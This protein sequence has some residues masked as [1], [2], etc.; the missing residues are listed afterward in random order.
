MTERIAVNPQVHFGK[1]CVAGTRIPV[2]QVLEL[3]PSEAGNHRVRV[4][5]A[6]GVPQ[7]RSGL[8]S[9]DRTGEGAAVVVAGAPGPY[10]AAP[11]QGANTEATSA[12]M[13]IRSPLTPLGYVE[14][15][16]AG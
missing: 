1:P 15:D 10:R 8:G 7:R 13:R 5:A 3:V 11:P 16:R 2:Q 14:R 4:V 6:A 12:P 9:A